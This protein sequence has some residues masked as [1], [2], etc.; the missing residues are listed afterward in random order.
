MKNFPLLFVSSTE[1]SA[2]IS[3]AVKAGQVRKLGPRLY[4]SNL[5]D[6]PDQVVRQ[7]CF[8]ILS[9]I[10]PG[11]IVSHRSAIENRISPDGRIY[12]TAD[13]SRILN[14]P[15]LEIVVMKGPGRIPDRD[16]PLLHLFT[17]CRER[18]YLENL[19]PSR[20]RGGEP[21]NLSRVE[22]EERLVGILD[23]SGA[24]ALNGLRDRAKEIATVLDMEAE[25]RKLDHIIGAIQGTREADELVSPRSVARSMHEGYDPKAVERFATLRSVLASQSFRLRPMPIENLK[26]F[27]NM[28][29]FDAYFSNFI[30]GTE[31]EVEEARKIVDSGIVPADRPADGHDILGTYRV[32]GSIDDMTTTPKDFDQFLNL[33][34]TRHAIILEGR[35]DK[36]PG[37]FKEKPNM[38]GATRFVE[39]TLVRGTLRQGFEFYRGLE[40][41][42]ARA[43]A[44][45]FIV[46]D[47]HPFNDGNGRLARAMMNSELIAKGE[48]RIIIPS[49]FRSEYIAGIKRMTRESDP[50]A[51]IKQHAHAQ[52]F[53][54]RIDFLDIGAAIETLRGCNAFAKPEDGLVLQ[55]PA[56]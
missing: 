44:I 43:L 18:A 17:S 2:D 38:A 13:Y 41:P 39:P 50:T 33:L 34:A 55:M 35:P 30:E 31:F 45:F 53:A 6:A 20:D 36:Q 19:S 14:L 15:G 5:K 26:T 7:N 11:V 52:E 9:L 32:V 25:F 4:T 27:Y 3:R 22:L 47:I 56:T 21:K 40:E 49:V 24:D 16:M 28:A 23:N 8:Q 48:A 10:L 12:V 42:F 54:S 46:S 51:F 1:Q 29:F 37:R